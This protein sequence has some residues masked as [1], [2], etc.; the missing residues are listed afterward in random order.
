MK[1]TIAIIGNGCA[2]VQAVE[3][4]RQFDRSCSVTVFS[5][6]QALPYNPMLLSYFLSDKVSEKQ[7]YLVEP[8]FYETHHV[9]WVAGNGVRQLHAREKYLIL[10]NG[11]RW[12]FEKALIASGASSFVPRFLQTDAENVF[13]LRT[14]EATRELKQYVAS[15]PVRRALVVGAS[16]IGIKVA[17]YFSQAGI[18][19]CLADGADRLFPLA[20]CRECAAMMERLVEKQNVRLRFSAFVGGMETD[21]QNRA[22]RVSFQ[23]GKP[24]EEV[25]V[26]VLCIGV[27]ANLSFVNPEEIACDKG[28]LV[29]EKMRTSAP[30]IYAAGDCTQGMDQLHGDR[31]IIGLLNNA[32]YQAQTAA[33]NLTG[34]PS[35]Y[36]GSLPHNITRFLGLI[37]TGIGDPEAEG[38]VFQVEHPETDQF[39][40]I[41]RQGERIVSVNLLNYPELSGILKNSVLRGC[42]NRPVQQVNTI[43]FDEYAQTILRQTLRI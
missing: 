6:S 26:V 8:D 29:D 4:I 13:S 38:E 43:G 42:E 17:E 16:M 12:D 40:R 30:D 31:R 35:V 20:A 21:E 23:D 19:C 11:E 25:D 9:E 32:R 36:G 15:H 41:V 2:S 28:I 1:T 39:A 10:E 34:H 5:D 24:A 7:F 18:D 27:R 37:F 3:S 22:V 33:W 14:L